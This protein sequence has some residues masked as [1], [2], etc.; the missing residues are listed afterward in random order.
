MK[1]TLSFVALAL[2]FA[3]KKKETPEAPR[4]FYG[5]WFY[6]EEIRKR[7]T[8]SNGDTSYT[9]IDT[10]RYSHNTDYIDFTKNG[11]ALRFTSATQQTDSLPFDEI[12]PVY[13]RL[14]SLICEVNSIDDSTLRFN[15]L[16]FS[17]DETPKVKI[18]QVFYLLGK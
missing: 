18:T 7:Y 13:F 3:C 14:D 16:D 12:T 1:R 17:Y 9:S 11:A 10:T 4:N 8:V 2:L 15:S 5:K 6:V